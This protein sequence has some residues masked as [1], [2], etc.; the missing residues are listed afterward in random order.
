MSSH[1]YP[2]S[3]QFTIP[4]D[5]HRALGARGRIHQQPGP[6]GDDAIRA[7]IEAVVV[8]D[9]RLEFARRKPRVASHA[10]TMQVSQ[11]IQGAWINLF[12]FEHSVRMDV[13]VRSL[14]QGEPLGL[15]APAH[16][17]FADEVA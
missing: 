3:Q 14:K 16:R 11:E 2:T 7:R 1:P 4:A 10:A 15:I 5:P 17:A 13:E 12:R 9:E 6:R 8:A